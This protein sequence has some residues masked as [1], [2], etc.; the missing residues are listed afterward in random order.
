VARSS[1]ARTKSPSTS[2]VPSTRATGK[3]NVIDEPAELAQLGR[4]T[5]SSSKR[6]G[7]R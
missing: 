3:P 2:G 6:A 1:A 7:A 4:H 5:I